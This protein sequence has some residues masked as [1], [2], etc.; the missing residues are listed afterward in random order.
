MSRG[1]LV[2]VLSVAACSARISDGTTN[3]GVTDGAVAGDSNG[4][5]S[6]SDGSVT[7]LC[8]SRQLYLNFD[9][10]TLY[11]GPSD[12]TTNHAAWMQIAQGTAPAYHAGVNNRMAQINAITDGVRQQLSSFP[13]TV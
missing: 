13:I 6:G 10:Q 1:L 9:G 5:G 11:Q 12:A 8:A 7:P 2:L 3:V 4:V